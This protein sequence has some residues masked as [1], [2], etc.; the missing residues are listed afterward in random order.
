MERERAEGRGRRNKKA[1]V[2]GGQLRRGSHAGRRG[3]PGA[4]MGSMMGESSG[5]TS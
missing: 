2:P 1:L 5:V 4:A 3:F